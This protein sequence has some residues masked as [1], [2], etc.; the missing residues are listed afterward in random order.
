MAAS[1]PEQ[2]WCLI[3]GCNKPEEAGGL[4]AGHRYRKKH[5]L[6]LSTPLRETDLSPYELVLE[7]IREMGNYDGPEREHAWKARLRNAVKSWILPE[8]RRRRRRRKRL[9]R[10]REP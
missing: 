2:K 6:S 8:W 1:E 7:A 3:P 9:P 4:C 10:R 5:G